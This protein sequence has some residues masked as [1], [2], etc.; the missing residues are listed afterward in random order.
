VNHDV[1]GQAYGLTVMTPVAPGHADALADHLAALP[2]REHSPFARLPAT[3]LARWV[4]VPGIAQMGPP[5]RR[6]QLRSPYL[7]FSSTFDGSLDAYLDEACRLI[8]SELDAVW[9]HCAGWPGPVADDARAFQDYLRRH[10]VH[11]DLFFA[12]YGERTVGQ[13]RSALDRA[14]R[15]RDLAVE[16]QGAEP[17]RL[18]AAFRDAFGEAR[19]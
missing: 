16:T 15:L 9:S 1:G 19:P 13:V 17:E 18:L 6:T 12:P 10:Q 4:I 14:R 11:T 5:R 2:T 7:L 8:P 3:H